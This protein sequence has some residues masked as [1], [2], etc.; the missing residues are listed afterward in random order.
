MYKNFINKIL[1]IACLALLLFSCTSSNKKLLCQK[2]QTHT[3][4][5][6]KMEEEIKAMQTLID[7]LGQNDPAL[8]IE[9]DVDSAKRILQSEFNTSLEEARLAK[10]NTFMEFKSNGVVVTTSI[11]GV[12]SALYKVEDKWIKVDEASL[13]GHGES[14]TFEILSLSK[15]T[16]KMKII[17]YGDT[18]FVVM[19]PA[20]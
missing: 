17:D 20:K 16:L 10:E 15:D 3:L 11:D 4:Q 1:P 8:H 18:S 2:W 7:T 12:D 9:I 14:M 19:I 13:K 6:A 5:N